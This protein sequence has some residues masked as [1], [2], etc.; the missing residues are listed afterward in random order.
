LMDDC[1]LELVSIT[2][3][4]RSLSLKHT[5]WQTKLV[6][7]IT[8][9]SLTFVVCLLFSMPLYTCTVQTIHGTKAY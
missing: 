6:D 4:R 5:S 3:T 7:Y 2:C 1:A 8:R 9:K